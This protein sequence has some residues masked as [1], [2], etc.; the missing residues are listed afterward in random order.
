M[1][2]EGFVDVSP[3]LKAGVYLL[4]AKGKV[5]YVGKSR[6]MIAR[7]YTHRNLYISKRKGRQTPEWLSPVKGIYFDEVLIRPCMLEALD[8]LEREMIDRYKPRLNQMLKTQEKIVAPINLV[9]G[10]V[11][12]TLNKASP[13][14]PHLARR[15]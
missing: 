5:I 1:Q 12:L 14:G 4:A 15:L 13:P 2:L 8:A 7:I 6:A 10:A 9:I 3:L 11:S